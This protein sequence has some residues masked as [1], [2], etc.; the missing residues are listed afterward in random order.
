MRKIFKELTLDNS[1][2]ANLTEAE[3]DR[4]LD[5]SLLSGDPSIMV[6]LRHQSKEKESQ[7]EVFFK[8]TENYLKEDVGIACHERRHNEELYLAKAVSFRDLH[9]RIK[10]KVP[11]GTPVP[12]IKWLRYQFQPINPFANTA[13]YYKARIKIKMMVQ[14]RQ[15]FL[16]FFCICRYIENLYF[17]SLSMGNLKHFKWFI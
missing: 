9:D 12:S 14:K 8:A 11:E 15:V 1:A 10:S 7:F 2:A 6:D 4:R 13:K 3:I 17:D 5:F 16:L